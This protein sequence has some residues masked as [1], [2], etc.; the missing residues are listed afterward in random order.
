MLVIACCLLPTGAAHA[1]RFRRPEPSV[2]PIGP[3]S[4]WERSLFGGQLGPWFADAF[5][6]DLRTSVD[7]FDGS[8]TGFHLEFFYRPHIVGVLNADL[9]LG[10]ISRGQVRV[11]R[12]KDTDSAYSFLGDLTLYPVGVGISVAPFAKRADWRV[13]PTLQA[14]GS[15]LVLNERGDVTRISQYY[16]VIDTKSHVELGY[17]AGAGINWILGHRLALVA[18]AKYQYAEFDDELLA[19]GNYSGLQLLFGAAYLYR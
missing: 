12:Y 5:G 19:G 1:Q 3:P 9:S 4:I 10:A 18:S 11:Q 16:Y 2:P 13:Q 14:G 17:Y 8:G 7:Q 6:D 15:L